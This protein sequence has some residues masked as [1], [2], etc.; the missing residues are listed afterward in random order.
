MA[1]GFRVAFDVSVRIQANTQMSPTILPKLLQSQIHRQRVAPN[2]HLFL[3]CQLL[4]DLILRLGTTLHGGSTAGS[5]KLRQATQTLAGAVKA[6]PQPNWRRNSPALGGEI[7]EDLAVDE[8]LHGLLPGHP[9]ITGCCVPSLLD[10]GGWHGGLERSRQTHFGR[11]RLASE[12]VQHTKA[13]CR[14]RPNPGA[15]VQRGLML[16]YKSVESPHVVVMLHAG[17]AMLLLRRLSTA[18]DT[19]ECQSDTHSFGAGRLI[20]SLQVQ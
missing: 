12:Q 14:L 19:L 1:V 2:Y 13:N 9:P 8:S 18:P 20:L 6:A 4:G 15:H 3:P 7:A 17:Y 16:T 11:D 5:S 10:G